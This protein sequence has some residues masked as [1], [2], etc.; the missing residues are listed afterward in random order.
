[1]LRIHADQLAIFE[2]AALHDF[3]EEM[4][5][6]CA[7]LSPWIEAA[8]DRGGQ[9]AIVRAAIARA[10][11]YG[12]TL[13]GPVRLFIELGF[14]LG[15]GFDA[16][17]QYPWARMLLTRAGETRPRGADIE[18]MDCAAGLH[19][20]ARD[21]L[22][23]IRGPGDQALCSALRRFSDLMSRPLS[24]QRDDVTRMA[25]TRFKHVHPEKF[26]FV[27]ELAL[28]TLVAEATE[29][30]AR[31]GLDTP[32]DILLLVSCM[33]LYGQG[34]TRDPSLPW[35]AHAFADE[36]SASPALRSLRFE[37]QMRRTIRDTLAA[38]ER[39]R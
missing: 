27:G 12:F 30:A 5:E 10:A 19:G 20:A 8:I 38:M 18:Q 32:W 28:R 35:I 21:A 37:E 15:H 33:F 24:S 36:T 13:K 26:A 23:V 6:H 7:V 29:E 4:V 31:H 2:H 22:R 34:C 25:L 9:V 39:N 14:L 11:D 1:M 17:V 16:D 3:E